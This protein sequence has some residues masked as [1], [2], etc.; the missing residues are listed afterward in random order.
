M[1]TH[2][3]SGHEFTP[4][5]TAILSAT[6]ERRC[7]S[8]MRVR[9]RKRYIKRPP[10]THCKN[11]HDLRKEGRYPSG[12]CCACTREAARAWARSNPERHL[13]M[14][15]ERQRR[16]VAKK[17]GRAYEPLL[18]SLENRSPVNRTHGESGISAT[19]LYKLWAGIKRRCFNANEQNYPRYGGR[20]I[21]MHKA[22]I[23]DYPAFRD[24]ILANIGPRPAG[25]TIDRIDNEGNYEPGNLRWATQSEQAFNRR[26]KT[27]R[28]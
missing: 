6:G 24:W 8:C 21:T 13:A 14:K 27:A 17:E 18:T 1:K 4:E 23:G 5:N 20:G 10:R 22:W 15:A 19:L 7:R 3:K 12:N 26:P 11:G 28:V 16:Y 25:L 2:C 9:D